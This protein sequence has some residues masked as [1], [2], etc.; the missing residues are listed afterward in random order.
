[1]TIRNKLLILLL[2]VS[3]IPLVAYFAL[4]VSFSHIVRNRVQN[5]LRS[6]LEE[7]AA[8]RLVETIDNYEK[9]LKVSA[10]AV[11]YG[12]RHYANEVQQNL[13]AVKVEKNQPASQRYIVAASADLSEQADKYRS[14][15]TA[16][17]QIDT[18]DFDSH[19]VYPAQSGSNSSLRLNLSQLAGT[20]KDI[21]SINP[22]SKLWVYT[23]L[24]DGTATLYPSPGVWPYDK[25]YDLRAE[26]W[27]DNAR[28]N[29]QLTP[30]PRVEPLTGKTVMTVGVPLFEQDGS[31][32]GAIA[33]DIDL[34]AALERM[35]IPRQWEQGAWKL[36]IRLPEQKEQYVE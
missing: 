13:W 12:L 15:T 24:N 22:E 35:R 4:D 36:L 31:F 33:M 30:T 28:T 25:G 5:T 11:R 7:K 3:L 9:N 26:P 18:V 1:M 21:Y 8:E 10:Q 17:S 27:Y 32:A 14:L 19:M 29:R 20:C 2:S 23:V 16:H 6:A 34:S